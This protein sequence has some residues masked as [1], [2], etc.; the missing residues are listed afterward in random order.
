MNKRPIDKT[1]KS[2]IK[3]EHCKYYNKR[4]STCKITEEPKW[5]WNRCKQFE[6]AESGEQMQRKIDGKKTLVTSKIQMYEEVHY[7]VRDEDY[8]YMPYIF[9]KWGTWK[10][11]GVYLAIPLKETKWIESEEQRTEG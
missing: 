9:K 8:V 1:K 10:N 2:N 5:Y 4:C 6:W 7:I 11:D 3:C